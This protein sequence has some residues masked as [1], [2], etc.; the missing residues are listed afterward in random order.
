[1]W[2]ETCGL[3][4]W[5]LFEEKGLY[6][7]IQSK[8]AAAYHSGFVNKNRSDRG[9]LIRTS[10]YY[11]HN[12][13]TVQRV[14]TTPGR[15]IRCSRRARLLFT[16]SVVCLREY[17]N[18]VIASGSG[19]QR[20]SVWSRS[21]R[22]PPLGELKGESVLHDSNAENNFYKALFMTCSVAENLFLSRR[23]EYI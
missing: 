5:T 10:I 14:R 18:E 4:S 21:P 7:S 3:C 20:G 22:R 19:D 2:P 6:Q 15:I 23:L 11:E 16:E 9:H 13:G 1:M 8:C 12:P 17:A